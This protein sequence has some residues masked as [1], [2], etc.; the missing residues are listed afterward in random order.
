MDFKVVH[1]FFVSRKFI[2]CVPVH[3]RNR[4]FSHR[5]PYEYFFTFSACLFLHRPEI[6][7]PLIVVFFALLMCAACQCDVILILGEQTVMHGP[8]HSYDSTVFKQFFGSLP[9]ELLTDVFSHRFKSD[10][11]CVYMTQTQFVFIS[12]HVCVTNFCAR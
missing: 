3:S 4:I 7:L 11:R 2:D 5:N 9:L 12:S 1:S 8:I 10:F 6:N